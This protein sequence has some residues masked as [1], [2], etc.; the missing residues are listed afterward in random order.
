MNT[1]TVLLLLLLVAGCGQP[2]HSPG[3]AAA[4]SEPDPAHQL[5]EKELRAQ[6]KEREL[7]APL[8]YLDVT[9]TYRGTHEQTSRGGLFR[10]PKYKQTGWKATG[11]I[12]NRAT[13]A[14]YKDIE[15][16]FVY[17]A[18]TG[19]VIEKHSARVYKY[20]PPGDDVPFELTVPYV[21]DTESIRLEVSRARPAPEYQAGEVVTE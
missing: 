8:N 18:A 3:E 10:D 6:L 1:P 17:L 9:G 11:T 19:S 2:K 20:V 4:E 5:S 15:L 12:N 16:T 21:A 14:A 7:A 13:L